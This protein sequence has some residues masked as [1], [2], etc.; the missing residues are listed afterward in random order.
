MAATRL[1]VFAGDGATNAGGSGG[2]AEPGGGVLGSSGGGGTVERG[3]EGM[4]VRALGT[5]GGA[6]AT[7]GC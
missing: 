2:G 7:D 3:S 4:G 5:A 1:S 6:S